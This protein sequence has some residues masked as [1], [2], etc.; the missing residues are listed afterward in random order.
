MCIIQLPESTPLPTASDTPRESNAMAALL[1]TELI[2]SYALPSWL[3][4]VIDRVESQNDLGEADLR[5]TLDDAVNIALADQERAGIDIVTDGEMRRR[6]FIQNFYGLLT[7]LDKLRPERRLGSAGYD[8]NPRYQ[9][10]DRIT[11]PRGLGIV[12]EFEYLKQHT[13]RPVKICIPGPVTLSLPL[14]LKGG[15]SDRSA[16]LDDMI[17]IVNAEMKALA[18]AGVTYLQVDEPRYATSHEAARQFVD[19][20]NATRDGVEVRVG[21]HLCF[22]NFMGRSRDRRDY[23]HMIPAVND[24]RCEQI[25]FEFANRE[26]AQI[27]LIG[28]L[29]GNHRIG[30]GVVDV[31]SYFVETPEQVAKSLR[32]ALRHA[33]AERLVVTPD[34]GFNHC[35]R[36]IAFA[37]MCAMVQGAAIVRRELAA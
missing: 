10:V 26:F 13:D 21:L 37:K 36:H 14:I 5:E 17:G 35:P 11:A 9:V 31:K 1:P 33:S 12:P 22:G 19:I 28:K 32:L 23:S 16:L 2:G 8:Q 34:C 15:Y 24:A 3:W 6:D 18:A 4:V 27:D 7:G 30:V 25:N 29:T 20:F